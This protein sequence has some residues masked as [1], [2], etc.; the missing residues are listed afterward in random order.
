MNV[1][2]EPTAAGVKVLL[3][4]EDARELWEAFQAGK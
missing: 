3:R 4:R 1:S 2:F